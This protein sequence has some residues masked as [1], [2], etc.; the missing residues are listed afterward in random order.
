[1]RYRISSAV[2]STGCRCL[3]QPGP[4]F[5]CARAATWFLYSA[6]RLHHLLEKHLHCICD[7]SMQWSSSVEKRKV[8]LCF[9]LARQPLTSNSSGLLAH[10]T[11]SCT[12]A[13]RRQE[14][15]THTP[16]VSGQPKCRADTTPKTL[17][18]IA[19]VAVDVVTSEL[20]FCRSCW[21]QAV[22]A[23][24]CVGKLAPTQSPLLL[25][26]LFTNVW[27]RLAEDWR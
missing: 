20:Y 8:W 6:L 10:C 24:M 19:L 3:L 21:S 2:S 16:L 7:K 26:G 15:I 11:P 12:A 18:T 9:S 22:W 1:M 14:T 27:T 17:L 5:H 4:S 13:H 23:P 25:K